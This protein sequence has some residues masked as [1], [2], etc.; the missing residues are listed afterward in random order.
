MA[1]L[2]IG[3]H[4]TKTQLK[5]PRPQQQTANYRTPNEEYFFAT[6]HNEKKYQNELQYDGM[7]IGV[8]SNPVPY[9]N[10]NSIAHHGRHIMVRFNS[11]SV[12]YEY[13]GDEDYSIR[14]DAER[15]KIILQQ[16][17]RN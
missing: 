10:T 8:K 5:I 17:H 12:E 14:Y 7:V 4:Y 6:I 15:E 11:N 1:K 2:K 16:T 13:I 3:K 9:G